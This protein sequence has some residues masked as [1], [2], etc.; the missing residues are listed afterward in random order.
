ML[1][2]LVYEAFDGMLVWEFRGTTI[3]AYMDDVAIMS[4][5]QQE[6]QRILDQVQQ[7]SE[8]LG[9]CTVSVKTQFY[10]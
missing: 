3:L 9:L 5:K 7:P 2:I 1:S 8:V 10:R 4:P 6:L